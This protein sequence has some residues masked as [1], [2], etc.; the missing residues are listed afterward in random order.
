MPVT[1]RNDSWENFVRCKR[2]M[3]E[4]VDIAVRA[5][6]QCSDAGAWASG[7]GTTEDLPVRNET[8]DRVYGQGRAGI[9]RAR[10]TR[11]GGMRTRVLGHPRDSRS[12][13]VLPIEWVA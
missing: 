13:S 12:A 8:L 1:H 9:F 7:E 6:W 11:R 2:L 5:G 4:R 3:D 10:P